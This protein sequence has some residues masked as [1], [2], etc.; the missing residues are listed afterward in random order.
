MCKSFR[1]KLNREINARNNRCPKP[2]GPILFTED[3]TQTQ[4]IIPSSQ[5]LMKPSQ[6]D[7]TL[8]HKATLNSYRKIEKNSLYLIRPLWIR[9][10]YQQQQK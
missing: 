10:G 9:P 1:Q 3:F 4:K 2:S 7:H 6:T 8:R 5:H